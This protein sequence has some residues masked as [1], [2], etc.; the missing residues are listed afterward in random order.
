MNID[1]PY[2][3]RRHLGR[4]KPLAGG[5]LAAAFMAGCGG[6]GSSGSSESSS[7]STVTSSPA[8]VSTLTCE[9]TASVTTAQGRL[10]NNAWNRAAV[11]TQTWQQCLRQSVKDGVTDIGWQW[12]WPTTSSVVLSYPRLMIGANP[13]EDG[14]RRSDSRF[15][16]SL[17]STGSLRLQYTLDITPSG[18]DSRF[19]LA[20][21]M[22]L[23]NTPTVAT[24]FDVNAITTEVMVWTR[25][26][27]TDWA[28]NQT[29]VATVTIDGRT[30]NVYRNPAQRDASGGSSHT[31][32][33]LVFAISGAATTTLDV[34][35][36]KLLQY[37]I[38]QGWVDGSHYI[39]NVE[40]GNEIVGGKG[41]TWVRKF[42]LDL[43][44]R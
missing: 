5:L 30:W 11:G 44:T 27:G 2:A 3:L 6:G 40:L 16:V 33:L 41:E 7:A 1:F 12:D 37:T 23:I 8:V 19:N 18:T 28:T 31:W 21:S 39:A 25:A 43:T 14:A 13:W 36:K 29:P 9:A 26:D 24:P 20:T 15:P 32:Q 22:W 42:A 38:D 35:L 17:Q 10:D 34:D 4:L